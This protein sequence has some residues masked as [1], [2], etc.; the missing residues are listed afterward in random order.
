MGTRSRVITIT[1]RID[2][3]VELECERRICQTIATLNFERSE[4]KEELYFHPREKWGIY[5]NYHK[6]SVESTKLGG[7]YEWHKS[8]N[9]QTTQIC[10]EE[11]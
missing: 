1:N 2:N 7:D 6:C 8:D 9:W 10:A 5:T 11:N 3:S 4:R